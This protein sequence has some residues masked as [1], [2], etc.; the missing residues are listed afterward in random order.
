MLRGLYVLTDPVYGP[1][2]SL[3]LRVEQAIRGGAVLIQYRDKQADA[4]QSRRTGQ[5]LMELC[6][7]HSVPLIVN[8]D[9]MLARQ[10]AADGVHL[11]RDDAPLAHAREILGRRALI[12]VTCHADVDRAAAAEAQG[13]DYVAFGSFYPSR[14]KPAATPA[15]LSLL[16][17]ARARLG[18]A[19]C[20]IGGI[21]DY[22]ARPLI[23]A[24]ADLIAVIAAVLGAADVRASASHIAAL[25]ND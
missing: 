19:I 16:P 18:I 22:N 10:I 4:R 3:I 1:E 5:A 23:E 11:G 12:G 25:F 21:A 20:G 9:V 24:G 17:A 2:Q 6:R 8:D 7:A 13:A 15:P 14:S